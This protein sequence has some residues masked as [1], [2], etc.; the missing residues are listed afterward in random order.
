MTVNLP[1]FT[2]LNTS[3]VISSNVA[4]PVFGL[5]TTDMT[6]T[7]TRSLDLSSLL[8]ARSD[9]EGSRG[10]AGDARAI[11]RQLRGLENMYGEVLQLLGVRRPPMHGPTWEPR[12]VP[13]T[14]S[15]VRCD[16]NK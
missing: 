13:S 14:H 8:D 4:F 16:I 9:S 10:G 6:S 11:R 15:S 7:T 12:S 1:P 3:Y 5:D 2:L